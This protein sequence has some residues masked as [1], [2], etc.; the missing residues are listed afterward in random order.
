MTESL[1]SIVT[2]I[3]R[4]C[5]EHPI[6]TAEEERELCVRLK[7][8]RPT[9]EEKLVLHNIRF[10]QSMV[11]RYKDRCEGE[12]DRMMRGMLGLIRAAR[13]FDVSKEYRFCTY[14]KFHIQGAFRDLYDQC[15]A[16]PRTQRNTNAILNSPVSNHSSK[17]EGRGTCVIDLVSPGKNVCEATWNPTKPGDYERSLAER[18]EYGLMVDY[19]IEQYLY[20]VS[21]K[22]KQ[23]IRMWLLGRTCPAIGVSMGCSKDSVSQVVLKYKP[24]LQHA[25]EYDRSFGIGRIRRPLTTPEVG[26]K[27]VGAFLSENGVTLA[28]QGVSESPEEH[29]MRI[30]DGFDAAA[31]QYIAVTGRSRD[32][33]DLRIMRKVYEDN[34]ARRTNLKLTSIRLGLPMP[35][36]KFLRDRAVR[37][38]KDAKRGLYRKLAARPTTVE[39]VCED[40][41]V[42]AR[43]TKLIHDS[44]DEL[45]NV[46]PVSRCKITNYARIGT[47]S[48]NRKRNLIRVCSPYR[49]NFYSH[50]GMGRTQKTK[51]GKVV[52]S[53]REL[54]MHVRL[55]N[56]PKLSPERL[57]DIASTRGLDEK[58]LSGT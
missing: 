17:D 48:R 56:V 31:E 40:D 50:I 41:A 26:P 37:M 15:L 12:E 49:G 4:V 11:S 53:L 52:M 28:A 29:V 57:S 44:K 34:I 9:L 7:D 35:Y 39:S 32:G 38:V 23:I 8:D 3:N 20:D 6:M 55:G 45:F 43:N 21:L 18:A 36:A 14:A 19:L 1:K 42:R 13:V 24:F 5:E 10:M 46:C 58:T 54:S 33:S 25:V 22:H 30:M 2:N 51:N 47:M 27:D 16:A